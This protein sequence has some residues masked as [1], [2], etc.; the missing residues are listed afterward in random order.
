ML[1][2]KLPD[3]NKNVTGGIPASLDDQIVGVD[4]VAIAVSDIEQAISWYRSALGFVLSEKR[5]TA[6][7][8]SAMVSAVMR[9]GGATVVLVQG[10]S[11]NSQ[12][13]RF[14]DQY[15]AGVHHVAFAVKDLDAALARVAGAGWPDTPVIHVGGVRQVYLRRDEA[16]GVRVELIEAGNGSFSDAGVEQ[17]YRAMEENN[18]Y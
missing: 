5:T 1:A 13:S 18:L 3:V 11:A 9:A 6:G 16:T 8:H 17:L 12:V 2:G 4:H 15:G 14:I 7:D 10:L